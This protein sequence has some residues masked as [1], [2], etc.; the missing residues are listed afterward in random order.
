METHAVVLEA[1]ATLELG[2][3]RIHPVGLALGDHLGEF[4]V[5]LVGVVDV[6]GVQRLV[7]GDLLV[8]EP[9]QTGEIVGDDVVFGGG[10]SGHE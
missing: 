1:E 6:A 4:V 9:H 2:E 3:V 10:S 7:L 8:R 5:E